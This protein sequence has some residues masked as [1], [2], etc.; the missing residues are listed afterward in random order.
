MQLLPS[1]TGL[2]SSALRQPQMQIAW[3]AA[4]APPHTPESCA[5]YCQLPLPRVGSCLHTCGVGAAC[6][7]REHGC[8]AISQLQPSQRRVVARRADG[9]QHGPAVSPQSTDST[10]SMH[11]IQSIHS[12][13]ISIYSQYTVSVTVCTT[14][15]TTNTQS[16][17]S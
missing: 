7:G 16:M 5:P 3:L 8:T 15:S 6:R 4:S 13:Y 12:P 11:N 9:G 10:Q 14:N 2:C 17:Y 1:C